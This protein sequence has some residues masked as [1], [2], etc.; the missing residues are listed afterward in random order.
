[1]LNKKSRG[2][3]RAQLHLMYGGICLNVKQIYQRNS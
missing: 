1:M 3:D 2:H